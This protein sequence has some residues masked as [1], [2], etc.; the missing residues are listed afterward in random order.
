M[1]LKKYKQCSKQNRELLKK[2]K[3]LEKKCKN[4]KKSSIKSNPRLITAK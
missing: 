3:T 4:N 1:F 2:I